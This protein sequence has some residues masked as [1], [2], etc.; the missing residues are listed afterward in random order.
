MIKDY[1]SPISSHELGECLLL[2]LYLLDI[3]LAKHLKGFTFFRSGY[4]VVFITIYGLGDASKSVGDDAE[5]TLLVE[6]IVRQY[7]ERSGHENGDHNIM[8]THKHDRE[9][10]QLSPQ[11]VS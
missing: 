2:L 5:P 4:L 11:A 1:A 6:Q 9:D 10:Q 3:G 7:D 8:R